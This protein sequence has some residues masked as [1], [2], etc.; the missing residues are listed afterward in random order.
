MGGSSNFADTY[1]H[2]QNGQ[3]Y[4]IFKLPKDLTITLVSGYNVASSG[5]VN[6][7]QAVRNMDATERTTTLISGLR[8]GPVNLV[9][10]S[11]LYK[12][13]MRSDKPQAR[14]FQDWVT[15][16]VLPS[17]RKTGARMVVPPLTRQAGEWAAA[18]PPRASAPVTTMSSR[19]IAE[20]TGKEHFNVIRDIRAMLQELK[21]GALS[22]EFSY[23]SAQ[24][25]P[26][27]EFRLPKDLT[28]T[29]VSGYNVTMRHRIVT[30]WM[31][32]E[33]RPAEFSARYTD[34]G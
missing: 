34:A 9:S 7:S 28:I 15:K 4:P 22:F 12:L 29:L 18:H 17:I 32:L 33:I 8:T 13:I 16:E 3:E 23:L 19:E 11:G 6:V 26:M 20:L 2:P 21:L 1:K 25:K 31:E 5:N 10:E 30:R 14:A 24:N 27:P